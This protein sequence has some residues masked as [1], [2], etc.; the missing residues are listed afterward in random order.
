MAKRVK[1]PIS[2]ARARLFEL[3][4]LVRA[5]DDTVVVF[6]QRDKPDRVVL[7]KE[8]RLAYL[9]AKVEAMEKE[10]EEPFEL[11]GSIKLLVPPEELDAMLRQIRNEWTPSHLRNSETPP[12]ATPRKRRR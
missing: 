7:V 1:V 5:G 10:E 12:A 4:N 9:E 3:A 6:E 11:A 8:T 2:A